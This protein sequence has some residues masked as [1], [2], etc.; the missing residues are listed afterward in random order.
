MNAEPSSA[1]DFPR[2]AL[3]LALTLALGLLGAWLFPVAQGFFPNPFDKAR[4]LRLLFWLA[5]VLAA[6]MLL[7]RSEL[8][9]ASSPQSRKS[10]TRSWMESLICGPAI[11]LTAPLLLFASRPGPNEPS[12]PRRMLS[13][14]AFLVF[15]YI[16][17]AGFTIT[18]LGFQYY[19]YFPQAPHWLAF[20]LW[21]WFGCALLFL[22]SPWPREPRIR[23]K[24][25][26]PP[27]MR[28]LVTLGTSAFLAMA[29]LLLL[30]MLE[31]IRS[32]HDLVM[33][34]PLLLWLPC[35]ALF[36]LLTPWP[37]DPCFPKLAGLPDERKLGPLSS[38]LFIL[39]AL[40]PFCAFALR[41]F[42]YVVSGQLFASSFDRAHVGGALDQPSLTKWF[43]LFT[44]FSSLLLPYV[45]LA[46]W[47]SD[48]S[49]RL[50][51]W[52]FALPTL[53]LGLLLLG[54][55]TIPFYWTLQYIGAMGF[56]PRRLYGVLYGL[57]G[58]LLILSV[59][60]WAVWPQK[61]KDMSLVESA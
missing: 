55:L 58:Y 5:S 1:W 59:F 28:S 41:P 32:P 12:N 18:L 56:T 35:A 34:I 39:L 20:S 29:L 38:A 22:L 26:A 40:A 24:P 14:I 51:Y 4:G 36:F 19:R 25:E 13:T 31:R 52:A 61:N 16:L 21:T 53:A 49:A 8:S 57:S 23:K 27:F 33:L 3:R 44:M 46:R 9:Q 30:V 42:L 60:G 54:I 47:L 37:G 45:A 6:S 50:G 15:P 7:R 11:A 2:P 10:P 48:R 43:F 17:M